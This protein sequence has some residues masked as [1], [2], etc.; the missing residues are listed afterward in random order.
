MLSYINRKQ[1]KRLSLHRCA[2]ALL[3]S[4]ALLSPNAPTFSQQD[5]VSKPLT[6]AD[7]VAL[8]KSILEEKRTDRQ[9]MERMLGALNTV[10]SVYKI[11]Y[12]TWIVLD[13]DLR[14]RLFKAFRMRYSEVPRETPV[15]VIVNPDANEIVEISIGSAV[16][17]RRDTYINLS[18]SLHSEILRGAYAKQVINPVPV[19]PR[20]SALF[21]TKPKFAAISASAFGATLLFSDGRGVEV[22]LGHEELGYHFWSAGDF[23]IMGIF[24]RLKLGI[25]IPFRYG[26]TGLGGNGP[27]IIRPRLLNGSRGI[28]GELIEPWKNQLIGARFSVGELN[29][30]TN[31]ELLTDPQSY[32]YLHT[33]A[34]VYYSR[35]EELGGGEHLFTLTGGL[36]YHQIALGETQPGGKIIAIEKANYG[37][38][39]L[40]VEYV[41]QGTNMYGMGIQYY[42]SI[43]HFKGW[44]ELIR[45]F[46]FLDV[47]YYSPVFRQTRPWEQSYF[48]MI[49]P[50]IQVVY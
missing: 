9:R 7:S 37:G 18:D 27:L 34:Q 29:E 4:I 11:H 46:I 2:C 14:E 50:R 16:M 5:S 32:Y 19:K 12:P 33:V 22:K 17:G 6:T 42:S 47:Q 24:D 3:F 20:T 39:I 48:F 44:V 8:L 13:D 49:S 31:L 36:G 15:T 43:L 26:R 25:M 1:V 30:V 38:P 40:R 45:N 41:H 35:P 21:G 28:S 10:D 23:R